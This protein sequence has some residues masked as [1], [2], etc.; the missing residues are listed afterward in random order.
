MRET[1]DCLDN[2]PILEFDDQ[3]CHVLCQLPIGPNDERPRES[4]VVH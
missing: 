3:T 1:E 4:K 2:I